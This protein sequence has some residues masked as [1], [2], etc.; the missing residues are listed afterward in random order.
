VKLQPWTWESHTFWNTTSVGNLFINYIILIP[1]SAKSVFSIVLVTCRLIVTSNSRAAKFQQIFCLKIKRIYTTFCHQFSI[2]HLWNRQNRDDVLTTVTFFRTLHWMK[3]NC[4]IFRTFLVIHTAPPKDEIKGVKQNSRTSLQTDIHRSRCVR[5]VKFIN[6]SIS[7]MQCLLNTWLLETVSKLFFHS[8]QTHRTQWTSGLTKNV[9]N[10]LLWQ[11]KLQFSFTHLQT[12]LRTWLYY[13][14]TEELPILINATFRYIT[15]GIHSNNNHAMSS[16]SSF[17]SRWGSTP[18]NEQTSQP[19]ATSC[20]S[21]QL[22]AAPTDLEVTVDNSIL[23]T[24]K[25]TFQ[26]LLNTV[27]GK[28]T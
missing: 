1:G 15:K 9:T 6:S 25:D 17:Y 18:A 12:L 27:T 20:V 8:S 14:H 7:V 26:N 16:T 21:Q 22:Q 28:Q 3:R 2:Y 4:S 10:I 24:M 23:M 19:A 11:Q 13:V 5:D